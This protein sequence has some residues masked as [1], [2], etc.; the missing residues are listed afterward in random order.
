MRKT[1]ATSTM[2][3]PEIRIKRT[4]EDSP[5]R[6]NNSGVGGKYRVGGKGQ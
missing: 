5:V 3:A 1:V 4:T 2:A 6:N